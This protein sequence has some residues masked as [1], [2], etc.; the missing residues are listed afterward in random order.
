MEHYK[1]FETAVN[2]KLGSTVKLSG[3]PDVVRKVFSAGFCGKMPEKT[4]DSFD[5]S[6]IDSYLLDS[7]FPFQREGIC[8]VISKMGR[9]LIADDMGLGKTIQALG[10]ACYYRDEWPVLIVCPSSVRYNWA[11]VGIL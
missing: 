4:I 6:P 10:I 5:L 8:Y 11:E 7:L 9:A 2:S 1:Q 3:L